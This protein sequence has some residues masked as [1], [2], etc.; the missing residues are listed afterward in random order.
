MPRPRK[1][2]IG[3]KR[4]AYAIDQNEDESLRVLEAVA[5]KHHEDAAECASS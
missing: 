3:G 2:S 1:S 5:R 4:E